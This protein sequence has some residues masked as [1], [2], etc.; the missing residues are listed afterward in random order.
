MKE[1]RRLIEIER[2]ASDDRQLTDA[3]ERREARN[4]E[5]FKK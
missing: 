1:E 2:E 3:G 4:L 5:I